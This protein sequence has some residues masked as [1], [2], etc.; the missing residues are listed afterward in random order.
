MIKQNDG[1]CHGA[2]TEHVGAISLKSSGIV[3][4]FLA[5][6]VLLFEHHVLAYIR[7]G[8]EGNGDVFS[9][10]GGVLHEGQVIKGGFGYR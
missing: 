9:W 8:S 2:Q 10:N 7:H 6:N 4:A 3:S 1:S 5:I